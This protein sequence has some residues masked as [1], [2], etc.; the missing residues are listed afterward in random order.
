ME[1][2]FFQ[3][4][5]DFFLWFSSIKRF[6]IFTHSQIK[7]R[8]TSVD[9]KLI[10]ISPKKI[11]I[12]PNLFSPRFPHFKIVLLSVNATNVIHKKHESQCFHFLNQIIFSNSVVN[13]SIYLMVCSWE[14]KQKWEICK[15]ST[16]STFLY[17]IKR[18]MRK[19]QKMRLIHW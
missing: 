18:L 7:Q 19:G 2:Y 14:W 3:E 5:F 1:L 9:P 12:E 15:Q 13:Q 8:K 17:S 10:F 11:F 16:Y 6:V 4:M